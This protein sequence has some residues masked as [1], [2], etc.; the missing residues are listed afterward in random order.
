[1]SVILISSELTPLI[2]SIAAIVLE[3]ADENVDVSTYFSKYDCKNSTTS[4]G[5]ERLAFWMVLRKAFEDL[6]I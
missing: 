1:M 6:F 5:R 3:S 4:P 2:E